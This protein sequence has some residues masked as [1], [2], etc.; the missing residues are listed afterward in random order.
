MLPE[1]K[2]L[3]FTF[4]DLSKPFVIHGFKSCFVLRL[5]LLVLL[6]KIENNLSI[7][8]R[9]SLYKLS[10][11]IP[12]RSFLNEVKEKREKSR[13]LLLNDT[14]SVGLYLKEGMIQN[15]R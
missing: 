7:S 14:L 4:I 10:K 13:I 6:K 8:L 9:I 1:D 12:K 5:D 2:S 3:F 15:C 11:S